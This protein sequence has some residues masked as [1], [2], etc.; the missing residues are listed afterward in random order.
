[1]PILMP[2]TLL[3]SR[4]LSGPPTP[5]END[6]GRYVN[7]MLEA[8]KERRKAPWGALPMGMRGAGERKASAVPYAQRR[9]GAAAKAVA[10]V[11]SLSQIM[12]TGADRCVW[13]SS[14][15]ALRVACE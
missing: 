3:K 6:Q 5:Q 1:M 2:S 4:T 10:A 13:K 12:S 15:R 8:V 7:A 9:K 11:A 14:L